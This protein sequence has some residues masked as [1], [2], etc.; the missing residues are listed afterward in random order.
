MIKKLWDYINNIYGKRKGVFSNSLFKRTL[1]L[2]FIVAFISLLAMFFFINSMAANNQ[3]ERLSELNSNQLW[4]VAQDVD[5]R[6]VSIQDVATQILYS[7]DAVKLMV[8][9][10]ERTSELGYRMITSLQRLTDENNLIAKAMVYLPTTNGIYSSEGKG[11]YTDLSTSDEKEVVE[12]YLS[13]RRNG[14]KGS[15]MVTFR[16][17]TENNTLFMAGDFCTPVFIGA[18]I[19]KLDTDQ[20]RALM[21]GQDETEDDRYY[22]YDSGIQQIYVPLELT[23]IVRNAIVEKN[24]YDVK[25]KAGYDES[26]CYIYHSGTTNLYYG[27]WVKWKDNRLNVFQILL[28]FIPFILAYSLFQGIYSIWLSRSIYR[29]IN[30]LMQITF[31]KKDIQENLEDIRSKNYRSE[32][33]YLEST[34]RDTWVENIQNRELISNISRDVLEQLFRSIVIGKSVDSD[35]IS[36]TMKGLGLEQY[37]HGRYQAIAGIIRVDEGRELTS[38]EMGMYRRSLLSFLSEQESEDVIMVN[39]FMDTSSFAG[40]LGFHEDLAAIQ[41]RDITNRLMEALENFV[42]Q[43]PY[44]L[45]L[46]S[47]KVCNDVDSIRL[48]YQDA[49]SQVE[50]LSYVSEED[51]E[52]AVQEE[53]KDYDRRYFKERAQKIAEAAEHERENVAEEMIDTILREIEE[54]PEDKVVSYAEL[55]EDAIVEKMMA[56]HVDSAEI[57]T[58]HTRI[59][60]ILSK[61]KDDSRK[62]V[63]AGIFMSA[64][65]LIHTSSRRSRYRYVDSA[66]EYISVHYSDGSLSLNEVSEAV[67][68]SAPYLSGIFSEAEQ[69]GFSAY[70]NNYRVEQAK[71]FLQQT[72]TNMTDV[73]YKCGFNS[74][75]SFNRV[76]KKITGFTPGQYR[77]H[78]KNIQTMKEGEQI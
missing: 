32:L 21:R 78:M 29:P 48:S 51:E 55:L 10:K 70:L 60:N 46:G 22:L 77:E 28:T 72:T 2:Q 69:M 50:Y 68:I 31:G 40:I 7:E 16:M 76:F 41:I 17:I 73:G 36:E 64:I 66:K 44:S 13:V 9:P 39:F 4:R 27:T 45:L 30:R 38:M 6:L 12:K 71:Q 58:I 63:I 34:F 67:G 35:Y 47:G 37:T 25:N 74:A 57:N 53:Q 33:D 26:N 3:R 15:D 61:P 20:I 56:V 24:Y 75:Q 23:D 5:T 65:H 59:S 49:Y 8:N 18:I 42:E 43:L 19:I 1:L 52:T 11:N 62:D 14:R 54:F